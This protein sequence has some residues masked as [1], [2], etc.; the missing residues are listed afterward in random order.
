MIN[1]NSNNDNVNSNP[2]LPISNPIPND[3]LENYN[4]QEK[5]YDFIQDVNTK[6]QLYKN[7]VFLK[8]QSE[9]VSMLTMIKDYERPINT[10]PI[11]PIPLM[12][13]DKSE[14]KEL[15]T[16]KLQEFENLN[17]PETNP[18]LATTNN[19]DSNI[20]KIKNL[21]SQTGEISESLLANI[22]TPEDLLNNISFPDNFNP[23]QLKNL[24]KIPN[25]EITSLESLSGMLGIPNFNID[26]PN[27]NIPNIPPINMSGIIQGGMTGLNFNRMQKTITKDFMKEF[28]EGTDW[29]SMCKFNAVAITKAVMLEMS[30]M[31][32]YIEPGEIKVLTNGSPSTHQGQNVNRIKIK[33]K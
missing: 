27:V 21:L 16:N 33:L 28:P 24:L 4:H 9:L 26:I 5:V 12:W 6:L 14:I 32:F 19:I 11:I 30:K 2:I 29:E 7:D 20:G 22:K 15:A 31:T 1:N 17:N 10:N 18:V 8:N 3:V 23:D 13:F 25:L